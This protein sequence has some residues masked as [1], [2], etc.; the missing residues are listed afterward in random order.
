MVI[1]ML[2]KRLM[3]DPSI[4]SFEDIV[5][6][7]HHYDV[8][9]EAIAERVTELTELKSLIDLALK[10]YDA[11]AL[12][13]LTDG[14]HVVGYKLKPGRKT[15]K[16]ANQAKAAEILQS[17]GLFSA[18]FVESK[19]LGVP[20]LEKLLRSKGHDTEQIRNILAGFV[21]ESESAPTTALT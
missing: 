18:E 3:E 21:T 6:N 13:R 4:K 7:L 9:P 15:R 8:N 10:E 19:M 17:Y 12:K 5:K 11:T 2:F 14:H 16:I 1:P 20:A